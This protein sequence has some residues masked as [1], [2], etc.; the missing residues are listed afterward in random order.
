L[1]NN[2]STDITK[3]RYVVRQ[4]HDYYSKMTDQNVENT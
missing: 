4:R 2:V 1:H 3:A